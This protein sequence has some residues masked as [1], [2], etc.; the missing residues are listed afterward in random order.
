MKS[1]PP[2][3]DAVAKTWTTDFLVLGQAL[4]HWANLQKIWLLL[5]NYWRT[6]TRLSC[7]V[8]FVYSRA[9]LITGLEFHQLSVWLVGWWG[10]NTS[11]LFLKTFFF[12]SLS[13]CILSCFFFVWRNIKKCF[14]VL[15]LQF[16]NSIF[17][18]NIDCWFK[19]ALFAVNWLNFNKWELGV[20]N[21]IN[22]FKLILKL[23][24]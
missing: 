24:C 3:Q 20:C 22:G 13:Q 2:Q 5:L 17:R 15:R 7:W 9:F 1:S 16:E 12:L 21:Y 14:W 8:C 19:V 4:Y 23:I 18:F 6:L 10:R 11:D